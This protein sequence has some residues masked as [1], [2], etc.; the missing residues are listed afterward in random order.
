[1]PIFG[2]FGS[3]K[4]NFLI[5]LVKFCINPISNVLISN[6][7]LVFENFEP[8]SPNVGILGQKVST[9]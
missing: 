7:T 8:K 1:M 5:L 3:K 2:H 4:I 9:F 6:L